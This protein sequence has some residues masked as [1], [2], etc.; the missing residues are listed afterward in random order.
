MISGPE[1]LTEAHEVARFDCG[2]PALNYWLRTH[3]LFN[4][5][6]DFT[7]VVVVHSDR[8]VVGF[9]GLA[10]T[11]VPPNVL[12]RSVRTG[13]HPDP[14]PCLLL[15]QFAVDSDWQGQGLGSGLLKD[16]LRRCIVGADLIGGR[17]LIVRA[18]D[19]EAEQYWQKRGFRPA[20]AAPSTLFRALGD[21][22][23]WLERQP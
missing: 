9:Y 14:V 11:A 3:A 4:Q 12:S 20:S 10:P 21:I 23:A 16:A 17:A 15:G 19:A 22:R 18:V 2:K 7:R 8:R 13:R 5:A 1:L 6:H